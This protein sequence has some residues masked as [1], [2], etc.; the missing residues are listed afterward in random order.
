M[1]IR[2][3]IRLATLRRVRDDQ[4][5]F[6]LTEFA[7]TAPVLILLYLGSFQLCNAI[8][9]QRKVAITARAL[10]D[11]TTQYQIVSNAQLDSI[12]A[13]SSQIMAPYDVGQAT[14]VVTQINIDDKGV[15]KVDFSR[16]LVQGAVTTGR[17]QGSVI[18]VPTAIKQNS[19]S[20]VLSEVAYN[21]SAGVA[22]PILGN[23]TLRDRTYMSPRTVRTITYNP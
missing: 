3:P 9:A 7:F 14:M 18:D 12:L 19:T 8:S 22:Q 2:M 11:L 13:A 17:L 6:A 5:G 21:Y 1:S 15:A 4:R 20:L 10:T 23:I 16:G